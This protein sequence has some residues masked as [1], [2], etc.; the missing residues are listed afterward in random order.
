MYIEKVNI[1]NFRNF[2]EENVRLI[3]GTNV[4]F[5]DNAQGKTNFIESV[6]MASMGKSFKSLKEKD[7][8]LFGEKNASVSVSYYK[9]GRMNENR[10]I[11]GDKK[12]LFINKVPVPKRIDFIGKLNTVLFTPQELSII[13]EGPYYRRK[14]M[15]LCISQMRIKYMHTLASYN[16]ALE[17]KNK[18]LKENK[19]ELL[20]IWNEK[21]AQ[22]GSLIL[23][24]RNS[25]VKRIKPAID[26]IYRQIAGKGECLKAAYISTV[27]ADETDSAEK[28]KQ[29][30]LEE[31]YVN[32]D[33][34]KENQCSLIGPHRDDILFYINGKNA[35]SFASQGQQRSVVLALKI[36][37]TQLFFEETGEYP[38][39][40]LDDIASE[41]DENR[42]NFLFDRIK[43]KQVIITCTDAEK[44]RFYE[45]SHYYNVCGGRITAVTEKGM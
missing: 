36:M 29:N 4:F 45:N 41:L 6:S 38:V 21:L 31:L 30:F 18:L 9:N 10:I 1:C 24:Y 43:D 23:W 14:F 5:G 28:I 37:Q 25:F 34:E 40:L 35:R 8:I 44:L 7:L 19:T 11:L 12:K 17:Q 42:R 32:C 20:D 27:K 22:Y 15:D 3:N 39:L 26:D 2:K 33:N 16:K 13:R